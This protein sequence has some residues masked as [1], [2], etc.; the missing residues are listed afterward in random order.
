[1]ATFI[2]AIGKSKGS[3]KTQIVK[4]LKTI[5]SELKNLENTRDFN[6]IYVSGRY[7]SDFEITIE[8]A[9]K[10]VQKQL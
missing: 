8:E 3:N 5:L 9:L 1:M 4:S 7:L 10:L 6:N 2:G